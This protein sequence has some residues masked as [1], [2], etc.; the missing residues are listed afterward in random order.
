MKKTMTDSRE[1]RKRASG[2]RSSFASGVD[3]VTS[4]A[5]AWEQFFTLPWFVW[6]GLGWISKPL[7]TF[8]QTAWHR[9]A[10][11]EPS[12]GSRSSPLLFYFILWTGAGFQVIYS[13]LCEV[14]SR[15]KMSERRVFFKTRKFMESCDGARALCAAAS[16]AVRVCAPACR[17]GQVDSMFRLSNLRGVGGR[18]S[19]HV[20][21]IRQHN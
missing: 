20:D 3:S 12:F 16:A 18:C 6:Q 17:A 1:S 13:Q 21:K 2:C 10:R 8:S 14:H 7:C 4:E 15:E 19:R 5:S 9:A 11:L